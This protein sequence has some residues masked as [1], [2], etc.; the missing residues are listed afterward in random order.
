MDLD[1]LI[2]LI[3]LIKTG[4]ITF[5]LMPELLGRHQFQILYLIW[6]VLDK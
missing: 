3:V 4:M 5:F 6:L 2:Y 1:M